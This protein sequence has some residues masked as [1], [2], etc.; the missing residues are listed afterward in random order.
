MRVTTTVII[1]HLFNLDTTQKVEINNSHTVTVTS[2]NI[3]IPPYK[4]EEV[5]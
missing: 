3:Y 4:R 1:I 2:H 5:E